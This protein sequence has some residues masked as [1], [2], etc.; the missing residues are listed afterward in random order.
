MTRRDHGLE[1]HNKNT[2]IFI[3]LTCWSQY[4]VIFS[5][6]LCCMHCQHQPPAHCIRLLM[7]SVSN[8]TFW[9]A[10]ATSRGSRRHDN[11]TNTH[12][13][14]SSDLTTWLL[15][16][17][18][19]VWTSDGCA[20]CACGSHPWIGTHRS[21]M[22]SSDA[23]RSKEPRTEMLFSCSLILSCLTHKRE[24]TILQAEAASLA[25]GWLTRTHSHRSV[26]PR[27]KRTRPARVSHN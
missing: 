3:F 8:H 14:P 13:S 10:S 9:M 11:M 12:R 19:M 24:A 2:V 18:W 5:R 7:C 22:N 21:Q 23:S 16:W 26:R 20:G 17:N 1:R 15:S 6:P 4:V 27:S 25:L